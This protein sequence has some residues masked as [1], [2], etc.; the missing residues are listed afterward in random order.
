MSES[1]WKG[2]KQ[3]AGSRLGQLLFVL[4]LCFILLELAPPFRSHPQFVGCVPTVEEAY[5]ITEVL[6]GRPIW[7][8][9]ISYLYLPSIL[10]TLALTI[11]LGSLLHL[12]CT[13]TA[14]LE[15]VVLLLSSSI[16]WWV[17]GHVIERL[18]RR[19][20]V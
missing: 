2:I 8:V 17:I 14:R 7:V 6:I 3:V 12:S 18:V 19:R 4:G 13:P 15:F 10:L 20:G 11:M 1:I 16:Q 9:A 5:T